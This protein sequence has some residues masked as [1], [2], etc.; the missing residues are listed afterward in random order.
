MGYITDLQKIR[1]HYIFKGNF[2]KD[3]IVWLP[4]QFP[5]SRLHPALI[6]F[7]FIK[8]IRLEML[9][10]YM[11][12]K[13]LMPVIRRS[14]DSLSSKA[15]LDQYIAEDM[16]SDHNFIMQKLIAMSLY[17]IFNI[18][19]KILTICYYMGMLWHILMTYSNEYWF[20]QDLNN[21]YNKNGFS[22][23]TSYD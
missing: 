7:Q 21:F 18:S 16:L 20:P 15:V 4:F 5:L 14:F 10:N 8:A 12:R 3:L 22:S 2:F 13:N 6:I 11:D 17:S 1:E 19:F 9:M 23:R